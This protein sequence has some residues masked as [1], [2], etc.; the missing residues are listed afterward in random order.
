M[1]GYSLSFYLWFK[2]IVENVAG[3]PNNHFTPVFKYN[4]VNKFMAGIR[5]PGL[6]AS[7]LNG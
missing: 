5:A 2:Y 3:W 4:G 1:I 7:T 6:S